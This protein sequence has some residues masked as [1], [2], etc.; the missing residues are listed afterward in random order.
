MKYDNHLHLLHL[1]Y[2]NLHLLHPQQ[3]NNLLV[4]ELVQSLAY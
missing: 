2:P 1:L 3:L 4:L